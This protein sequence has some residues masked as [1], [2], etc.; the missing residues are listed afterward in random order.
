MGGQPVKKILV[1]ARGIST[2]QVEVKF[3]HIRTKMIQHQNV[4]DMAEEMPE[5]EIGGWER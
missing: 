4:P 1:S 2:L 3:L 5:K